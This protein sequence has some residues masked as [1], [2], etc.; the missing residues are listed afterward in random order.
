MHRCI[1]GCQIEVVQE[2]NLRV[3]FL[4]FRPDVVTF[5]LAAFQC[6]RRPEGHNLGVDVGDVVKGGGEVDPHLLHHLIPLLDLR[7]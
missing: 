2:L 1:Q 7:F 4:H 5:L 3:H 6:V